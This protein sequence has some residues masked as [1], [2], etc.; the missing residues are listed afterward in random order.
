MGPP[1]I[2]SQRFQI[3]TRVKNPKIEPRGTC[4][5]DRAPSS[6]LFHTPNVQG[7]DNIKVSQLELFIVSKSILR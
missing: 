3:E 6:R 1:R 5:Y 7:Y 4:P 2:R